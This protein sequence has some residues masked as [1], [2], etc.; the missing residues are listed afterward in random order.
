M[1]NNKKGFTL[2]ELVIVIA[3]IG[4]LSGV[5]INVLNPDTFR[6]KAQDARRKTDLVSVQSAL[7]LYFSNNNHYPI[8]ASA[9]IL[10]DGLKEE[11]V[12]GGYASSI[13]QD[14]GSGS[15]TYQSTANGLDYELNA[16][17]IYDTESMIADGGNDSQRYEV[18]TLLTIIGSPE[19]VQ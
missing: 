4:I 19:D 9:V 15:Y 5:V 13:P 8:K 1:F 17:L 2:I 6:N 12:G 14:P 10:P 18:G 7:E 3:V 11:L 16:V